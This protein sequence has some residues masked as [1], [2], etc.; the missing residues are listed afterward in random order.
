MH[1]LTVLAHPEQKS[2]NAQLARLCMEE[3]R[4]QG[5][6]V[7]TS[8]LYR[9]NFDPLE[10]ACHYRDLKDPDWFDPQAQQKS[11]SET[12]S[13]P[14]EVSA[15]ISK[16]ERAD[17]LIL[18]YPMWWYT[19]PAILKGWLDRV[20]VYGDV[21]TSKKRY[22]HGR[23]RGRRAMLSLT[24]GGPEETF[25]FNGRNA[26]IDLLLWPINFTLYYVGYEVLEPFVAFGVEGGLKYSSQEE[27]I[28]RLDRHRIAFREVLADIDQRPALRFNGSEDWDE[29]GRLKVGV[30]G[31]SP[32]IRANP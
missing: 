16:L 31:F 15:E 20:L 19:V 10:R 12:G 2:F 13:L 22:D 6:T 11:A 24:T 7:E 17:F 29:S 8:D 5:Y 9:M 1:A 32:F 14:Q 23:F 18:Q 21:Y 27:A 26:D 3:L 28:R 30:S 4:H 25:T